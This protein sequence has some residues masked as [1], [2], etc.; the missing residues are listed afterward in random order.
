MN[1]PRVRGAYHLG[2]AE[3]GHLSCLGQGVSKNHNEDP[4]IISKGGQSCSTVSPLGCVRAVVQILVPI[5]VSLRLGWSLTPQT[6]PACTPDRPSMARGQRACGQRACGGPVAGPGPR[7][8]ELAVATG[9]GMKRTMQ[10]PRT[11][12]RLW[13]AP[14]ELATLSVEARKCVRQRL[15][16]SRHRVRV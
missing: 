1:R 13:L 6:Q 5:E 10:R 2:A 7:Q 3:N 12:S 9:H 11:W 16:I 14:R 8:P 4:R 15:P